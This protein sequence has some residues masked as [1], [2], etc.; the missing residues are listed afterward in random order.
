MKVTFG[1]YAAFT[2]KNSIR[3]QKNNRLISEKNVPP[4]VVAHLKKRLGADKPD[5]EVPE[6]E[7]IVT[8]PPK[9]VV[10]ELEALNKKDFEEME[11]HMP[12][13]NF[14]E[15]VSIHTANIRDIAEALYNRF[16]LYTVY[17]DRQPEADEINPITG[18]VF[19]KYH[20]GIAYQ[21][22]IY[23][24]NRGITDPEKNRKAMDEAREA[25]QQVQ[26]DAPPRTLG[27]ARERNH[28]AYRTSVQGT[29]P[30]RMDSLTHEMVDGQMRITKKNNAESVYDPGEDQPL[31]QPQFGKKVIRPDWKN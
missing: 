9:E 1:E 20:L 10:E 27:E 22:A 25:H 31:V 18:E 19:T 8:E 24:R 21:A 4:E 28:F 7:P 11:K 29:R 3:F 26:M 2:T 23:A 15:S 12:D 17:L 13:S 5:P 30:Q 6:K 14:L 16:G